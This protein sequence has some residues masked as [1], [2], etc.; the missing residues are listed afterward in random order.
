MVLPKTVRNLWKWFTFVK[1]N[2]QIIFRGQSERVETYERHT[3]LSVLS[4]QD[5]LQEPDVLPLLHPRTVPSHHPSQVGNRVITSRTDVHQA[6][7]WKAYRDSCALS[8]V[9][10]LIPP[11]LAFVQVRF[12]ELWAQSKFIFAKKTLIS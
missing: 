7:H 12:L 2:V 9:P 3:Y 6:T 4:T 1:L 10:G 5:F 11:P 8:L